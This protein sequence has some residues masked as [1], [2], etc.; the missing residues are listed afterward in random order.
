M[1]DFLIFIITISIIVFVHESGHFMVARFFDVKVDDFAIGFGKKLFVKKFRS[2]DFSIRL[3]PLGG[4]V[5][6]SQSEKSNDLLLFENQSLYKKFLI[7]AAGPLINFIFAFILLI[8]INSGLQPK[9]ASVITDFNSEIN[10]EDFN[11]QVNDR[12]LSLN[13]KKIN[14]ISN[15]NESSFYT[16][17]ENL[18]FEISRNNKIVTMTKERIFISE[19]NQSFLKD[20]IYFFPSQRKSVLVDKVLMN[21]AASKGGLR[22]GDL[23]INVDGSDI[24]NIR[25][26]IL[27]IK[28]NPGRNLKLLIE[29]GTVEK[30]INVT[31]ELSKES[32]LN[33]GF[34]GVELTSKLYNQKSNYLKYIRNSSLETLINSIYSFKDIIHKIFEALIQIFTGEFNFKMLSGPI[35]IAQYSADSILQGLLP[36]MFMLVLLNINVGLINLLPIPTLDG[37]HLRQYLIEF[38]IRKPIKSKIIIISQRLGVIFLL[39]IMTIAVYNDVFN[40]LVT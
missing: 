24:Y 21:S 32:H 35:T 14:S 20:N 6:F 34:I 25:D 22:G 28:K 9:I 8:F 37:G 33:D 12:I 2:T 7:V 16:G 5:R 26:F 19:N 29:R 27:L 17:S 3:I 10:T 23:I 39:L 18:V 40:L 4:F 38:I 13:G 1:F 36:Y 30:M 15:F 11:I 31:P